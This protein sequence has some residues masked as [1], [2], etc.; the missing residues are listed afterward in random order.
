MQI[1]VKSC[2]AVCWKSSPLIQNAL[3]VTDKSDS[4]EKV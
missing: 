3:W 2:V 1:H 4:S